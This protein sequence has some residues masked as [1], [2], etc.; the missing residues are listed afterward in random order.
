M[1]SRA[2]FARE[3][4]VSDRFLHESAGGATCTHVRSSRSDVLRLQVFTRTVDAQRTV[5]A[6]LDLGARAHT[7]QRGAAQARKR[8]E[9]AEPPP[10]PDRNRKYAVPRIRRMQPRR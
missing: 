6:R 10:R 9:G 3:S 4:G 1:T 2:G 8:V 7:R 5:P